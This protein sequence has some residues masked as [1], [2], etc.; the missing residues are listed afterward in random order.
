[1]QSKFRLLAVAALIGIAAGAVIGVNTHAFTAGPSALASSPGQGP[2]VQPGH[3]PPPGPSSPITYRQAVGHLWHTGYE[4]NGILTRISGTATACRA[5]TSCLRDDSP[6]EL[7]YLVAAT[8]QRAESAAANATAGKELEP[9]VA[10]LGLA[11]INAC[12]DLK[13]SA[14]RLGRPDPGSVTWKPL[15]LTLSSSVSGKLEASRNKLPE[16][17]AEPGKAN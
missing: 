3:S 16:M 6:E 5:N 8:C 17:Q 10:A 15:A 12:A 11:L 9:E 14:Q 1:M 4:L 13:D 2:T 7:E